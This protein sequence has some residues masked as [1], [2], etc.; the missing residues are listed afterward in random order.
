MADELQSSEE[1]AFVAEEVDR[2]I[3]SAIESCLKDAAYDE[4]RVA[5]WVDTICEMVMR[6][7]AELRKPLKYVVSALIMQKNGAGVHSAISCHWDTVTDGTRTA[8]SREMQG[9]TDRRSSCR[10]PCCQVAQ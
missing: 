1:L 7:L 2:I 8:L 10:S 4:Q 5:Q 3:L 6:G 9:V